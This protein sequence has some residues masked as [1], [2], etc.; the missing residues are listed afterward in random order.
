M[1]SRRILTVVL[2][3]LLGSTGLALAEGDGRIE[4]RVTREGDRGVGGVAVVINETGT[5]TVSDNQGFFRFHDKI[6]DGAYTLT[7]SLGDNSVTE[8]GVQVTAGET[9]T[10]E[11]EVDWE[12]SFAET[13]TVFAA[14]RKAERIVEAPA[15]VTTISPEQIKREASHGQLPKLLEFTPGAE[16]TQSGVYDYNFNTRGFNSSLNRRVATLIDGRNPSVPFLGAQEWAAIG[17]PLDDLASVELVRGPSAA[18][19]GANA[20]SGVLNMTSRDPRMSLGGQLRLTAGELSTTNADFRWAGAL[21]NNWYVKFTGGL[22]DHGDYTVSRD[23]K[24]EYS[25]LCTMPGQTDCLP[26]EAVPLAQEDDDQVTFGSARVDKYLKGGQKFTLEF[27]TAELEG[28]AFQTGIGRVQLLDVE[29]PWARFSVSGDHFNVLTTYSGREADEQLAL[30][31]GTNLALDTERINIEAQGNWEVGKA[32]FVV[33]GSYGEEDIDSLDPA[34]GRQ[35][36]VFEPVDNELKAL[37]GQV[38]LKVHDQVKL[39][40]AGRWDDSDLHDSEVSPKASVVYSVNDDHTLRLTYNEAFQVGNY[41]EYF[42]NVFAAPIQDLSQLEGLCRLSGVF[43]CGLAGP[44]LGGPGTPALALGNDDLEIEEVKMIELGYSAIIANKA[45]LTVDVYSS[46]NENFITDLLPNVGTSLGRINPDFQ[47]W[48]GSTAA[49]TMPT[50]CPPSGA[51]ITVADCIRALAPALSNDPRN[52]QTIIAAASYTNF[53]DVD[54]EGVDVGLNLYINDEWMWQLSYSYFD[55][56]IKD[57]A[58]GLDGLLVPNTPENKGATG[59]TYTGKKFDG[60]LNVRFTDKFRWGVGPFQGDVKS[61][62]TVDLTANYRINDMWLV[63]IN[64]SNL[65]DDDHYQSFGG[66]L[67]ER[68]ALGHVVLSWE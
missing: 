22:R 20:S 48:V 55:F 35:T 54:T 7:F 63:G 2:A 12:F 13:I 58:P 4:G 40:F 61:Y 37:F 44:A 9:T 68:R 65:L 3:L 36:L 51:I 11:K 66:D 62:E 42:L 52:G 34:T 64:V 19:Y 45:F 49:E 1:D 28:P 46:E 29:R 31:S 24:A 33:G 27:G 67:L 15:S 25:E 43:D 21:G 57:D 53:G 18:L 30:S 14:S 10:V 39:V 5:A 26:R 23:V 47:P 41:S 38:D 59:V 32:R 56:D 16:V 17:F 6:A 50:M 8:S 60:S